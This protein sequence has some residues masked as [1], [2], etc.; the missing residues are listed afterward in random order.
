MCQ[1]L[2]PYTETVIISFLDIYKNIIG[3]FDELTA[4]DVLLGKTEPGNRVVVIG[5]GL[6][7]AETAD[8]LG[9]QCEQVTIIEMLPQIMK[10]GEA[11]PTK[12][13][14]ERFSQ[15]GVQIH[16]STKLLEIGDHTVTA[17]KTGKDLYLK[18]LIRLLLQ[19]E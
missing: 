10:D 1:L 18:I 4:H 19:S 13:M 8:M 12:Y 6:V 5:G 7:G 9:Q 14:K 11:A 3:K 2:F 15:N 16:T 17:E